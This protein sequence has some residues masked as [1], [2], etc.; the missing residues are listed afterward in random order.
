MYL[1]LYHI[2]TVLNIVQ[3]KYLVLLYPNC[4]LSYDLMF[5]FEADLQRRIKKMENKLK[6][7]EKSTRQDKRSPVSIRPPR[8][9]IRALG[10]QQSYS[11]HHQVQVC[12]CPLPQLLQQP[13]AP[14]PPVPEEHPQLGLSGGQSCQG[15]S[16]SGSYS[17]SSFSSGRT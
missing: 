5:R 9:G 4:K 15:R 7:D 16:P 13:G 1:Y 11:F 17:T 8:G 3:M 6:E 10:L 14:H 2:L 12:H